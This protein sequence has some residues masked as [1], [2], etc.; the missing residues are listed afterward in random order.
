MVFSTRLAQVLIFRNIF[1]KTRE[2]SSCYIHFHMQEKSK[3]SFDGS[4]LLGCKIFIRILY[5][6]MRKDLI[7]EE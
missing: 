5:I 7:L 3:N 6:S 4:Y 2:G 1:L